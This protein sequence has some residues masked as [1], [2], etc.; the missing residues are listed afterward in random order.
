VTELPQLTLS[1]IAQVYG[2]LEGA[3]K[4]ASFNV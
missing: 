1:P 2:E 3:T 4:E